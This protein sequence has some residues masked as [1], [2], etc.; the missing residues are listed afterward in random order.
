MSNQKSLSLR[1]DYGAYNELQ[2]ESAFTGLSR[3]RIIN[4]AVWSY[5]PLARLQRDYQQG[6]VTEKQFTQECHRLLQMFSV[7]ILKSWT[8]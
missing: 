2:A 5:C 4:F 3:N 8:N 1:L 7:P 6:N